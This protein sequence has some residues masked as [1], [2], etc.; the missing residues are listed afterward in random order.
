[1]IQSD[2]VE[3]VETMIQDGFSATA[4]APVYDECNQLWQEFVSIVIEHYNREAN[5]VAHEL[6]RVAITSKSSCICVD[7]PLT[8]Y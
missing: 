5:R 6:A 2:Y 1:M 3:V 4:S 7:K 8:L